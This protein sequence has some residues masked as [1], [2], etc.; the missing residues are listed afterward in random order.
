LQEQ[1]FVVVR[2]KQ[3]FLTALK[4]VGIGLAALGTTVAAWGQNTEVCDMPD[5]TAASTDYVYLAGT[6]GGARTNERFSLGN[7]NTY[8]E[9]TLSAENLLSACTDA[10]VIGGDG[11]AGAEC[12]AD[13]TGTDDQ[14][15]VEVPYTPTTGT[16]WVD[17]DPT[18]VLGGLDD[19]AGRLTTEEGKADNVGVAAA[20]DG[21]GIDGTAGEGGTYTPSLD[22]TEINDHT[23]GDNSDATLQEIFD[24]TGAG[25]PTWDYTDGNVNLSSGALQV[26]GDDVCD[27]GA[28]CSGYEADTHAGEH[29]HSGGDEV[30]TATP[31]ANVIPKAGAGGSLADDFVDG[32][33]E[34]DEINVGNLTTSGG[35]D[36][37]VLQQT[38]ATT[39]EWDWP[40]FRSHATDCTSLTDGEEGDSCWQ[41]NTNTIYVCEPS[42]GL[43]DTPGEWEAATAA[44]DGVGY[45]EVM[46]EGAGVTK[47]AQLNF[48]GGIVTCVDN[49]SR[50]ECTFTAHT[51]DQVGTVNDGDYCQ[52]GGG[53]VLDC[54]QTVIPIADGGTGATSFTAGGILLGNDPVTSLGVAANGQIPI[55]DGATDPVLNEI[56][57]TTNEIEITDG[58]GTIQIGIVTSPTLDGTN[59]TGIPSS[60][61]TTEVRSMYWPAGSMSSDGTNC[62][63]AVEATPVTGAFKT[64]V[65]VCGDGGT[66]YGQA[67]LPDGLDDT[68]DVTWEVSV[69]DG[70]GSVTLAGDWSYQCWSHDE[71]ITSSW[72]TGAATDV[73][74]T[75]ADD[76]YQGTSAGVDIATPCAAGDFFAWRYVID[77]ANHDAVAA[78]ILGVKFEYTTAIGD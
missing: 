73:T 48:I 2:F 70:T 36:K 71:A 61:I 75:T 46:E 15:A 78:E 24:P 27:D 76:L 37:Y 40:R 12:Q 41:I 42:A 10:Q 32:S 57:G 67:V 66:F 74:L 16:D 19:L 6:C 13:D 69:T 28:V 35:T 18:E 11:A 44:G 65:I 4:W 47:R 38:G 29:Q 1:P 39:Y 50:T 45:D 5:A 31:A 53:S 55:G 34:E 9:G 21:T 68:A 59:F 25:N 64:W 58:P 63:D 17:P 7:L 49:A 20:A 77:D 23:F 72:S 56:D 14:T 52:G 26:G 3:K 22:L 33:L 8:L 62:A 60:A 43:C 54:D 30:A 51:P